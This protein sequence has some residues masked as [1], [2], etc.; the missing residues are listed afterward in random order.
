M[1]FRSKAVCGGLARNQRCLETYHIPL[2]CSSTVTEV[3]GQEVLTAVKVSR[4]D[5][6]E[7]Q[8]IPCSSLLVAAGLR[9]DRSLLLGLG[10][11]D[12]VHLC[13]NCRRVHP[14]VE[15][16]TAEGKQAGAA[17]CVRMKK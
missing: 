11:P 12:W 6:G 13:G 7:E 9:P 17:A 15:A 2:L 4:S 10:S 8:I 1:L 3:L 16:V 5:T 14:M